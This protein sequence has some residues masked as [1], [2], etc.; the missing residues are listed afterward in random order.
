MCTYR[1]PGLSPLRPQDAAEHLNACSPVRSPHSYSAHSALKYL[2]GAL[3]RATDA[4]RVTR[5]N[6]LAGGLYRLFGEKKN[7]LVTKNPLFTNF[8]LISVTSETSGYV[9]SNRKLGQA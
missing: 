1:K 5:T 4:M 3:L 7:C 9:P 2:H 6:L 8:R